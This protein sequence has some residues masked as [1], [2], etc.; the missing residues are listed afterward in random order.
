MNAHQPAAILLVEQTKRDRDEIAYSLDRLGYRVIAVESEDQALNV[1]ESEPVNVLVTDLSGPGLDGMRLM[2]VALRKSPGIGVVMITGQ[3]G[4]G[5]IEAAVG[6]M[7]EGAYDVLERPVPTEKLAAEIEKILDR[8]RIVQENLD[9]HRQL[10]IRYGFQNIIGKS[11]AMQR[12]YEQV[13]Q[14]AD[15]LATVLIYGESGTGK[16]LVAHAIHMNSSRKEKPF[17]RLSCGAL[18][19]GVIE[20]ELFGHERGAFTG[21]VALRKGRFE[22]ADGGTLF[23]DEVGELTPTIQIKLLRV[24]QEREF[25]RVGGNRTLRTDVRLIAATHRN[26][27]EEVV[28]GRFRE[29]LYYRLKVV[30]L[31]V[32]PLRERKEDLPLLI[33]AFIRRFSERNGKPVARIS[34]GA[35]DR[36]SAYHWPGNVRELENCIESMI[37]MASGPALDVDDVPVYIR[38]VLIDRTVLRADTLTEPLSPDLMRS[39]VTTAAARRGV[40]VRGITEEAVRRLCAADWTGNGRALRR[41]IE[42]MVLL[43]DRE[44]LDVPDIPTEFI[45]SPSP[46]ERPDARSP[47]DIRVGM[48]MEAAERALIAA[49]L[50]ACG[51]NKA[52]TARTLKIG[53][54][55]LFRKIKE[56]DIEPLDDPRHR[57]RTG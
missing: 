14:I 44:V 56:Y 19:E 17:V 40:A 43:A 11:A 46:P 13:A 51:G 3:T 37:V 16:E 8:Q 27:E 20:S 31:T 2:E 23:L 9:L 4:P 39:L 25:E 21:A 18:S 54:R 50:D 55:T 5:R 15:T 41:C 30:T 10:E 22:L 6:A 35:L 47:V 33:E 32:P 53:L 28:R 29:D 24:L 36:L 45:R 48:S 52:K 34:K 7:Q 1:L 49:T 12:I 38:D 57:R 26:L 42:T